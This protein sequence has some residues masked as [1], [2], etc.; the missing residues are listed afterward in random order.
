[1]HSQAFYYLVAAKVPEPVVRKTLS[2]IRH[3][4]ARSPARVFA[5][6]MKQ[7]AADALAAPRHRDIQSALAE[8]SR[9][10]AVGSLSE[11]GRV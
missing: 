5:H 6:R 10:K 9:L 4:G 8:L 11:N 3:D 1:M 7:Y 2:E